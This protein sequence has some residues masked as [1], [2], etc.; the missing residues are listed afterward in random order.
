ME[1]EGENEKDDEVEK[2]A[3]AAAD[4]A[5]CPSKN[6]SITNSL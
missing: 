5:Q 1:E 6:Q 2:A 3:R 4:D